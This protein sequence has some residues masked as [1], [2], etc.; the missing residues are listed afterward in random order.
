MPW[1]VLERKHGV[2]Y[3][4]VSEFIGLQSAVKKDLDIHLMN[5]SCSDVSTLYTF[6]PRL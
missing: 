4:F 6:C 3:G 1:E 2:R 5:E